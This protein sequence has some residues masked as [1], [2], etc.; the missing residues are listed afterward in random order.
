[1]RELP[2]LSGWDRRRQQVTLDIERC[3]FALVADR[4][5]ADTTMTAVADAAGV[6]I[7]TVHRY[8]PAKED[9]LLSV[10]RRRREVTLSAMTALDDSADPL[11]DM[12]GIFKA[13]AY[14]HRDELSHYRLWMRAM[15][16]APEL[17]GKASGDL[18]QETATEL[19]RHVARQWGVDPRTDPRPMVLA[20]ALLAAVDAATRY[21]HQR[22][23]VDP[24]SDLFDMVRSTLR[25]G[26]T[27]IVA[28]PER[29][30]AR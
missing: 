15:E 5:Y 12:L 4:G 13:L 1:M 22:G 27:D 29:G 8:F 7:R 19:S 2:M 26:F 10:V 14:G 25:T 18:L 21:W 30:E 3:A 9:L 24:W 17:Q 16:Q 6:S 11:G 28:D 23:G 20:H